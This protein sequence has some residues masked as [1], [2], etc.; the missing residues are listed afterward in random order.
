MPKLFRVLTA[1]GLILILSDLHAQPRV[2]QWTEGPGNLGLGYPVPIPMDTPLPFDGFRSYAGLHARHQDL[3]NT[4]GIVYGEVIGISR[5]GREIWGYRIGDEDRTTIYGT[6]EG[7]SLTNG[8]IHAREWQSPEVV[9]GIMELM[10]DQAGDAYFYDYLIDNMNMIVIPVLNVDGFQQTQRFPDQSWL[11]TDPN[12]PEQ[13]PRD[14]RMRRK[15]M[16]GV[17]EVMTTQ[18]DHLFGVDLNR[19][20][21]PFWSTMAPARSS[22][23]SNSIVHHG[24]SP[25]SEPETQALAAAPALGPESQLR[26]YTDVHSFS[27]VHFWNRTASQR[28]SNNTIKVFNTFTNHH[29]SF[30][31]GK[32]YLFSTNTSS[33]IGSGIGSTDEFFSETYLIPAWTLEIEPTNTQTGGTDIFPNDPGCGADYGGFASNCHDGFI[34]P[35]SEIR[36]VREELAQTFAS[37]FYQQAGPPAMTRMQFIESDTQALIFEAEWDPVNENQRVLHINQLQPIEAEKEYT[38]TVSWDKPMRWRANDLVSAFPG[39]PGN[40][41]NVNAATLVNGS[42]LTT[43]TEDIRWLNDRVPGQEGYYRYKDDTLALKVRFPLNLLNFELITGTVD[44]NVQMGTFDM[45]GQQTDADPSTVAS[46]DNGGWKGYEDT[47]GNSTSDTGGP[48]TSVSLQISNQAQPAP[49]LVEPSTSASWND[50]DHRGEG[51]S[52]QILADGRAVMYW[53]TY[54]EE[55]NQAWYIGVGDIRGNRLIF[56]EL[57]QTSGGKFGPDFD[58]E[59]VVRTVVG[60]AVFT[61]EDCDTGT[62]V[63]QVGNRKGRFNLRRLSGVMGLTCGDFLG[64]PV[65]AEAVQSGSWYNPFQ[66]GH[67]FAIEVLIDSRVLVYWFTY[68]KE[69]NQAWFFGTGEIVGEELV[70]TET[71]STRGPSFGPDFNP[72]DLELIPWG[73]LRFDLRCIN[74]KMSYNS[75][76]EEFGSGLIHLKRLTSLADL[77]CQPAG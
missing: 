5:A 24:Q 61:Y 43:I 12:F 22:A 8:G 23:A 21:P 44:A 51:F 55:G 3:M 65:R 25:H 26:I 4:S 39:K 57:I 63:Y 53:F 56:D 73:E 60:S 69:G 62:M 67:G 16:L 14:G 31:A 2:S 52:I 46:W 32:A 30:P 76:Q 19:N 71:F 29:V 28:L 48:D 50:P 68:D 6:A 72:D 35:E 15:N 17:D 54:D 58:P 13:V 75:V 20:N 33:G 42:Q 59:T 34:L 1:A 74:G 64:P 27:Q 18:S 41:L 47:F 11:G 40:T 77:P 9:T 37:V 49:F 10:V 7:A 66:S 36:R 45:V 38:F 70:I